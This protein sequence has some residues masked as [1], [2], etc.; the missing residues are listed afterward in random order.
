MEKLIRRFHGLQLKN[1]MS[2]FGINQ[3]LGK[4]IA[5]SAL[6]RFASQIVAIL[7]NFIL[8]RALG[9][10]GFGEYAFVSAIV[11][12]G[13]AVTTF[14]TD[15]VLIRKISAEKDYSGLSNSLVLQLIISFI[16]IFCV[17]IFSSSQ[18]LRLYI[19]S[20]IPLS[21]FTISTIALRGS[22]NINLFSILHFA[23]SFFQFISA[24]LVYLLDEKIS[25]LVLL[26]L[27]A[28]VL[29]AFVG[30]LFCFSKIPNFIIFQKPSREKIID[31]MQI[32]FPL[33][34]IGSLRLIYERLSLTVFPF[35]TNL[36]Y[37][38]L[39]SAS[40]RVLDAIKLGYISALTPIY[41]EMSR[42]K[43]FLS[44]QTGLRLL[45][46]SSIFLS[47]TIFLLAR[48]LI[49]FLFGTEFESATIS[50]QIMAWILPFYVVVSYYSLGFLAIELEKPVLLSLSA[51]LFG[52]MTML[53]V[54]TQ[55]Y[56]LVGGAV[57]VL[58]AEMLQASL[59]F[60]QWRKYAVS[61]LSK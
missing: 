51:S 5:F 53:I 46:L 49:V 40:M 19:F 11:L 59:L 56:G 20:L 61:K 58:S 18:T 30:V 10:S 54:L 22:H 7:S 60:I 1:N 55:A 25:Q 24:C 14:G 48:Y 57:A 27:L 34:I 47:L 38:G 13:N 50:L 16:L 35:L 41:P 26:L 3:I 39:F 28:H 43:N 42:D 37:A 12:I 32:S 8:A 2:L 33:A 9:V 31:L 17:F 4:N 52:L 15:M 36:F 29:S 45:L 44:L 21:F 6:S 23:F